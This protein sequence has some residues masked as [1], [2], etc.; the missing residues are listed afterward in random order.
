[1]ARLFLRTSMKIDNIFSGAIFDSN[2]CIPE[3]EKNIEVSEK[4]GKALISAK[5]AVKSKPVKSV[6]K[7]D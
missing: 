7:D 1:M 5:Q 6:K 2:G 4:D 3:G